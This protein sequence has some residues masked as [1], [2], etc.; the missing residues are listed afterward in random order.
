MAVRKDYLLLFLLLFVVLGGTCVYLVMKYKK[1]LQYKYVELAEHK[2]LLN[3][4]KVLL[5]R[6]QQ[7]TEAW[8]DKYLKAYSELEQ[9]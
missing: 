5:D 4:N 6:S 2:K 1:L 9:S 3:Q 8:N 7:E